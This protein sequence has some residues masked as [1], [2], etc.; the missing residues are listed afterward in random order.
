MNELSLA[1]RRQS[2][3]H[4]NTVHVIAWKSKAATSVVASIVAAYSTP[5]EIAEWIDEDAEGVG[6]RALCPDCGIDSVIGSLSGFPIEVSFP[7]F[8]G[9]VVRRNRLGRL[10]R[11]G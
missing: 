2:G 8:R 9:H 10:T 1:F 6:H 4:M 3:Q 5:R 11:L 7:T